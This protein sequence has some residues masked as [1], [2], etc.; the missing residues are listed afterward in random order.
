MKSTIASMQRALDLAGHINHSTLEAFL[1]KLETSGL[2]VEAHS[3]KDHC[4]EVQSFGTS[5]LKGR[6][7]RLIRS[8]ALSL[9]TRI[10]RNLFVYHCGA[11][12]SPADRLDIAS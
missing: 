8:S 12:C 4:L 11:I 1:I 3:V 5:R 7:K 2:K 9:S 6:L 10:A